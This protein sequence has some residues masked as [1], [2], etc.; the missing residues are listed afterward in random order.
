M[1]M[2]SSDSSNSST[3]PNGV[4]SRL[5]SLTVTIEGLVATVRLQPQSYLMSLS[6]P[7]D[8]HQELGPALNEL[9]NDHSVRV[10][11]IT[12]AKDGEFM[13]ARPTSDYAL[14][15][16]KSMLN[17]P[18]GAWRTFMGIIKVH[19]AMSEMEKPIIAKIN[20]DAIG[21][22]QSV[23]FA[24][25]L[26]V[27]V[28]DAKICDVHLAMGEAT[29][30]SGQRIGPPFGTVPGDGAGSLLPLLMPLPLAKQYLWLSE[31]WTAKDFAK[32]GL[33]NQV[34][35]RDELDNATASLVE[36]SLKRS[37]FALAWSKRLINRQIVEQLNRT[38]DAAVAYEMVNL[39][40][41]E[42]LGYQD[43]R[44]LD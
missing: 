43:P 37:S 18:A 26:V 15:K 16:L 5:R 22:G 23:M 8:L 6:P 2:G 3:G 40:Q 24:S 11:I 34:V 1:N 9:R 30:Q 31:E 28:E 13:V 25:D 21:F 35:A 4:Y 41:V 12:G 10:V 32:F 7:A 14:P 29:T 38:L 39:L 44:Q 20:G 42:R 33:I 19:Q 36:S 17:D 27:A